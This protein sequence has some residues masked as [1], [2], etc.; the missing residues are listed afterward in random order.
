MQT[1][2]GD[3]HVHSLDCGNGFMDANMSTLNQ[4]FILNMCHLLY[5]NYVSI[6]LISKILYSRSRL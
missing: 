3:G 1:S 4:L 2:R 5:V 6:K